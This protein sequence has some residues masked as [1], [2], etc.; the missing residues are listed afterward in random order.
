MVPVILTNQHNKVKKPRDQAEAMMEMV[1]KKPSK[2]E[3]KAFELFLQ[4]PFVQKVREQV[5]V[6]AALAALTGIKEGGDRWQFFLP[7]RT[8]SA[9]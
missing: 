2:D 3:R 5:D 9:R 4:A 7:W 1:I 8:S 6:K